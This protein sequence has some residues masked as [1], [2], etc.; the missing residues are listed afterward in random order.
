[1]DDRQT[2]R[3]QIDNR[4]VL[5][6]ISVPQRVCLGIAAFGGVALLAILAYTMTFMS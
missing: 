1:M 6:T 5:D 4:D 3:Q 2:L